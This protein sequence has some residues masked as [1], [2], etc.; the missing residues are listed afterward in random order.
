MREIVAGPA[1]VLGIDQQALDD[2]QDLRAWLSEPGEPLAGPHE[3][4]DAK[5]FLQFADLPAHSR[6]RGVQRIG[7]LGEVEAPADGFS[8][9]A[10]LLEIHG[11]T[12]AGSRC[13][14]P[15]QRFKTAM[16]ASFRF[17]SCENR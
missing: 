10:Q 5:L 1:Q 16:A 3:Q 14:A 2:R 15:L 17:S 13:P 11:R 6:L 7:H 4:H 8:D 9:G 12:R